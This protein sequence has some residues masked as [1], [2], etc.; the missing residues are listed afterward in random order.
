MIYAYDTT[1]IGE[2]V[3]PMFH[4]DDLGKQVRDAWLLWATKQ[5]N[6]KPSWLVPWESL[7]EADKEADRQIGEAVARSV[8]GG[9]VRMENADANSVCSF[10]EWM[11]NQ[12]CSSG[13]NCR[14]V[15]SARHN[16]E[17]CCPYC[18]AALLRYNY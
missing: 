3:T 17:W 14:N 9:L 15:T 5:P 2:K 13:H 7:A 1:Q 4:R 8:L 16:L 11:A 6:P 12:P 10:V 18:R